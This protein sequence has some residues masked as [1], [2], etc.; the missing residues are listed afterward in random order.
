MKGHTQAC[1]GQGRGEAPLRYGTCVVPSVSAQRAFLLCESQLFREAYDDNGPRM[2]SMVTTS[3]H[4][5][6][7]LS[8]PSSPCMLLLFQE[9]HTWQPHLPHLTRFLVQE[10][11]PALGK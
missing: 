7:G 2:G 8:E 9:K 5:C 11:E 1:L 4:G 3:A 6:P 10:A